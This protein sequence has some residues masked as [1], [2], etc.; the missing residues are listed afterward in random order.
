MKSLL[1]PQIG[2]IAI[3]SL[4]TL[5]LFAGKP[6]WVGKKNETHKEQ[7]EKG[8]EQT[9]KDR[10]PWNKQVHDHQDEW[11]SKRDKEHEARK[12]GKN[13]KHHDHGS[14]SRRKDKNLRS[15]PE[16]ISKL[17]NKIR[18]KELEIER[19]KQDLE[20]LLSSGD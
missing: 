20:I 19:L 5:N 14:H 11:K 12:L 13:K 10:A 15:K 6:A 4:L 9:N 8:I 1:N 7:K 17:E 3:F 18:K 2:V 16:K